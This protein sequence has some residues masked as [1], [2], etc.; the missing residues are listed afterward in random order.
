MVRCIHTLCNIFK[1]IIYIVI[2]YI[3]SEMFIIIKYNK[4]Y[5]CGDV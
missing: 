4:G 2:I 3:M 1:D 5:F